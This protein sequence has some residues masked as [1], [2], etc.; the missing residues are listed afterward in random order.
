VVPQG[1]QGGDV[2]VGSGAS[3]F[4]GDAECLVFFFQP[5]EPDAEFEA[6][7]GQV[8][9]CRGLLG[10]DGGVA[11]GQI[12]TP[13]PSLMRLVLAAAQVSQMRGSGRGSLWRIGMRPSG[14]AGYCEA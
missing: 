6:S 13:V 10:Q 2:L 1:P 4:P 12:K 11:F 8:V 9:E 3:S 5:A 14:D 7:T